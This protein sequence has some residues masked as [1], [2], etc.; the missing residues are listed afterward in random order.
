M[1]TAMWGVSRFASPAGDVE[2]R[3]MVRN[4]RGTRKWYFGLREYSTSGKWLV[5]NG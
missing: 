4:E 1:V 2:P 5:E 3:R